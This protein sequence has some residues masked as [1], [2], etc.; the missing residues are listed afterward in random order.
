M[1]DALI[2]ALRSLGRLR[3]AA[4]LALATAV[5]ASP[6]TAVTVAAAP[7]AAA[8]AAPSSCQLNSS[9]GQIQHVIEIQFD[10]THLT[11]DNPNVPSDLEQ[12]PHLL[13]FIEH[14]GIMLD[15]H[16]TPLISHTANDILTT[17]TGVY[18]DRHGVPVANSFRY[19]LPNGTSNTGV[20]FA[21]WTDPI[22]DPSLPASP[23]DTSYNMLTA[24]GHNA[25]APWVPF[26]RAGCNFGAVATANIVLENNNFDIPKVFGNPSPEYSEFQSNPNLAFTDFV[27]L[28]VHCAAG[29]ALCAS[30]N[31]GRPDLL[32]DE[33][34]G[35]NGFNALFGAKYVNPQLGGTG[36]GNESLND[37]SGQPIVNPVSGTPGFP[38]FDGMSAS[39]S[40]AYVA[41]MQEHGIPVT[42]AYIS[43]AHDAHPSGPAYGPGE[44]GYVAALKA[45]DDAFNAFFTRLASDGINSSNT[46][47]V[48]TAD[49]NDH[50]VGGTPSNAC[51]GVNTACVYSHVNCPTAAI[52]TCPA[53]NVGELNVNMAGLLATEQGVTTPFKVHSDSAPTVYIT[54]NPA[55]DAAV[56]RDFERAT[57][58]LTAT[59]FYKGLNE[60]LTVGM[61]DP[62]ELK[63]LH[64]V[65]ADPARTETFAWFAQPD[66]FLYAGAPNCS[67]PCNQEQFGFAWNHGDVTPDI[68]R[69]W[70]GLVGPGITAR[71]RTSEV[72][73]DHTDVRPTILSLVGL[74][75]DYAHDGRVLVE[76]MSSRHDD[77]AAA[78]FNGDDAHNNDF[79]DLA[80]IY[81][82][83]NAPVGELGLASLRISTRALTGGSASDDSQ[84]TDLENKLSTITT[85]RNALAAQMI[86]LLEGASFN[87]QKIDHRT[88]QRL[89]VQGQSLLRE[90]N[91]LA[92]GH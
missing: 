8:P 59:N 27:G 26:T 54:G 55:R 16:H 79:V 73:S 9:S 21:Y 44:A 34:G 12:M 28:A 5:L 72:W 38:G 85:Q 4:T 40:L 70:L 20:S 80:E 83:I 71:G 10:N 64:M 13:S 30:G 65:T 61:A 66:Y 51:D 33:P 88:A 67:S 75:D 60:N 69:T 56:T 52:P 29:D 22:F 57:G 2:Q 24:E 77:G 62:V 74:K 15:N 18:P 86:A 25:P 37:L 49:E 3:R 81:K 63:L 87:G 48:F 14:N 7:A 17:L 68:T 19:F 76:V 45:Y 91:R 1:K 53:N 47:F 90:V 35:Y 50:F 32:P 31:Q 42:Y 11:R 6:L 92:Y 43:D 36:A 39:V 46:L 58:L 23:T 89:I 82:Q 84:Y 78:R 41:D